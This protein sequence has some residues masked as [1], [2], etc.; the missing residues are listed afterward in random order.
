MIENDGSR[1]ITEKIGSGIQSLSSSKVLSTGGVHPPDEYLYKNMW[2][3]M[4]LVVSLWKDREY[5]SYTVRWFTK[6]LYK[7]LVRLFYDD[8]N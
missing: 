3:L 7:Y 2:S 4:V 8:R 6:Y 1:E 5:Y